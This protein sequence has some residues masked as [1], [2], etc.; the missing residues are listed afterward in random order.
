MKLRNRRISKR[1]QKKQQLQQI[2]GGLKSILSEY[3]LPKD[4]TLVSAIEE[5]ELLGGCVIDFQI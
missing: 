3:M 4:R 5:A 2:Y 1:K